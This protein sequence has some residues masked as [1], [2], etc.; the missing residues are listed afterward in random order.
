MIL[1]VPLAGRGVRMNEYTLPKPLVTVAGRPM[2]AWAL[3]SLKDIPRRQLVFVTLAEHERDF[4]IA[5]QLRELGGPDAAIVLLPG[6]TAGQ[7]CTVLEARQF[8]RD[9]EDLLIAS[10]DTMVVSDLGR[11]IAARRPDC[12]GIISVA[13][14]PGERWS[15][16]RTDATGQVVEVAEKVRISDHASTGLYY[17]ARTADFLET[18]DE[19]ISRQEKTR[20][21]YY[22]IPVYQ[23]Y[24]ERGWRVDIDRARQMW[25]LGTPEA[26][27]AF[28]AQQA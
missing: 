4:G 24:I 23:K 15:F 18:A 7:L 13:N 26:K 19:M 11:T 3:D 27:A 6:V 10:A 9:E 22:V 16:A 14:L 8:F 25:D 12:R 17:F 28:E 1:V 5:K 20:G 21:E 2:I